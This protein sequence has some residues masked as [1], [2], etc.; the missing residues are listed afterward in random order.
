MR[1]EELR[2]ILSKEEDLKLDFKREYRIEDIPPPDT[3][4]QIWKLFV[5]GQWDEFIKDIIAL[6]NGNVGTSDEVAL[7]IIGAD[8]NLQSDGTRQ[9]YNMSQIQLASQKIIHRVNSVCEPPIPNIYCEQVSIDGK[10]LYVV[11][12][13]PSPYLHETNRQLTIKKGNFNGAGCLVSLGQDKTYTEYT[14]FIRKGENIYP[15]SNNE[16]RGLEV[17]KKA[18]LLVMNE[19]LKLEMLNNLKHLLAKGKDGLYRPTIFY[20][21][22]KDNHKIKSNKNLTV[23]NKYIVRL[24]IVLFHAS[25]LPQRLSTRFTN[26]AIESGRYLI[27]DVVNRKHKQSRFL[28]Y[29][30]LL[31]ESIQRLSRMIES[32]RFSAF[33][34]KYATGNR[35]GYTDMLFNDVLWIS[36]TLERYEDVLNISVALLFYTLGDKSKLETVQVNESSPLEEERANLEA[37]KLNAA[38]I[39]NW[40]LNK[41]SE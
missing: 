22:F 40:V 29:L 19:N 25:G 5:K 33:F 30:H 36:G 3:D 21:S 16:R 28:E 7:L 8:D 24:T 14:A 6:T 34:E 23:Q 11:S 20:R 4:K 18:D 12:I 38:E 10:T 37:E 35:D 13:P 1:V 2:S 9:L 32:E 17:D 41:A 27:Y 31:H 26:Q 15:A 39:I